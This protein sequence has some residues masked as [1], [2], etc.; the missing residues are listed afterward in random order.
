MTSANRHHRH[1]YYHAM[2]VSAEDN[3]HGN[4]V[5]SISTLNGPKGLA[6]WTEVWDR[7]PGKKQKW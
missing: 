5:T 2:R 7:I 4:T 6:T 3:A 1:H